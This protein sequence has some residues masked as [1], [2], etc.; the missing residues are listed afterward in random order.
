M[1]CARR[2][3]FAFVSFVLTCAAVQAWAQPRPM[4]ILFIGNSL[5]SVSDIPGRV[6]AL[7]KAMGR[8][9]HVESYTANGFSLADHWQ[10]G[11]ALAAIRKGWD[12]VVLQQGTSGRPDSAAE[13][14][15]YT[16]RFAG[17]IRA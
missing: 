14:V 13:L 10:D 4:R 16:R 12:V 2:L 3:F 6:A 11:N 15:E 17:P 1:A 7:A 5:T 8:D 9:A